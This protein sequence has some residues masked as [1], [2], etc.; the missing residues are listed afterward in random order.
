MGSFSSFLNYSV[1]AA[2]HSGGYHFGH[3]LFA[4]GAAHPPD[5]FQ[6]IA[7]VLRV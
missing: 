5:V 2:L 3:I 7:Q 1:D 6:H 4:G